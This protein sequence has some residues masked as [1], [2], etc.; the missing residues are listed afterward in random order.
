MDHMNTGNA[1]ARP[2]APSNQQFKTIPP[3][4]SSTSEQEPDFRH[5]LRIL[6]HRRWLILF[7]LLIF[8][9]LGAFQLRRSEPIYY[10]VALLKFEPRANQDIV[11]F[12]ERS[13]MLYQNDEIATAVQLIRNPTI[14]ERVLDSLAEKGM[15]APAPV[16]DSSPL[17]KLQNAFNSVLGGM[18]GL[19]VT[20]KAPVNTPEEQTKLK[21]QSAV[22]NLLDSLQVAQRIDTKLIEVGF[23]SGSP[24]TAAIIANEFCNQYIISLNDDKNQAIQVA[25]KF[26][27]QQMVETKQRLVTAEKNA[28]DYSG[29]SD[30]RVMDENMNIAI[31]SMTD[32]TQEVETTRNT[33]ALLE[34][35]NKAAQSPESRVLLLK[36]DAYFKD[37]QKKRSELEILVNSLRAVNEQKFPELDRASRELSGIKEKMEEATN[38]VVSSTATKLQVEQTKLAALEAR[39]EEQKA[40]TRALETQMIEYRVL[41]REV[42]TSQAV[43]TNVME[44]YKRLQVT[45]TIQPSNV[46]VASLAQQPTLPAS[47]NV[48][49]TMILFILLGLCSGMGLALVLH[50]ADRSVKNP[51][52]VEE[53]LGLPTLGFVPFFEGSKKLGLFGKTSRREML[54]SAESKGPQSEAFHYLRTSIQYSSASHAPQ[55]LLVT[56][57]LPQE[58]KSTISSNLSVFFASRGK[59]T[60]LIDADLKRPMAHNMFGVAKIPGLSDVLTGQAPLSKAIVTTE[61]PNLDVLP[62]GLSTP[63]PINLL[64]SA[65]MTDLIERLRE[66]YSTIILDSAPCHGMADSLVLAGKVDAVCL[67]VKQGGTPTEILATTATK[68][69]GIGANVLGVVYNAVSAQ[70]GG[71]YGY[72]YGYGYTYKYEPNPKEEAAEQAKARK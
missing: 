16:E 14:A 30:L 29:Q 12:G 65:A 32:L 43:F 1:L 6:F 42:D 10:S 19:L 63:S 8:M 9:L 51:T 11:D 36:D 27:D 7:V 72:G 45:S 34:A 54:L 56:S 20:Y 55:A 70:Q 52:I 68:L 5:Y 15:K 62:A 61:F 26:L 33:I 13:S 71:A 69:R 37:L 58:G 48:K 3:T 59:K 53:T 35:E 38:D 39:L 66:E 40:K 60:I 31:K 2:A 46:T 22:K 25:R 41:A 21:R 24:K 57:C 28:Q 49:R 67:V 18:R 47:P 50:W 17:S 4:G 44:G 64:E 23:S